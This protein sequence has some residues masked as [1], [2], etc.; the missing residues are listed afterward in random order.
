MNI[1][2]LLLR[3]Y[4]WPAFVVLCAVLAVLHAMAGDS[5][6]PVPV[7]ND[8]VNLDVPLGIFSPRCWPA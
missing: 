5:V 1:A 2:W 8:F 7:P 6:I 3:A 4:R